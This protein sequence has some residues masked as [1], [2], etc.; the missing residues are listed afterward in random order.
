LFLE[1]YRMSKLHLILAFHNH[2]PVGNFDHVLEDCYRKSYLPLLQTL[3]D[4]PELK[5]VLHY[6]GHLLSW[7]QKRH[8]E[9][10]EILGGMVA[11]KR[12][13]LLSGGFYEPI[14]SVLPEKDRKLQI[15]ELSA[16][17]E[18]NLGYKPRGMWL[19]ER[20]WEPQMPKYLSSAGMEYLPVDDYHF[21]LTGL[22][23]KQLYGY[24]ITEDESQMISVFPGSEKLRYFIPFR[25]VDEIRSYFREVGG[26]GNNPLLTM[27]DD[28]EKFGSWPNTYKHCYEDGWLNSFFEMLSANADWIKTTTFSEYHDAF[29]PMGRVYLPTASYREMGEWTLPADAV[30]EYEHLLEELGRLVGERSKQL[31]R[32]SIWRAFMVKYDEANHLHKKMVVV[33]GKVH[34]AMKTKN[35]KAR[36]A[37]TELWKGQ[38]NDAYWHGI[39]GGLYLPH[40][41]SSLYRHL[42]NAEA[43]AHEVLKEDTTVERLDFDCDGFDDVL[44]RTGQMSMA[45]T[46]K[47]GSLTEL[48]LF[49]EDVNILDSLT[50]RREAYHAKIEQATDTASG[51]LKT[52]HDQ[53]TA[54]ESGLSDHLVYDAYR[55][56]SLLD[57]FLPEGTSI[58]LMSRSKHEELGDF[59]GKAYDMDASLKGRNATVTFSRE[60]S[61]K[62]NRI[63][64]DKTVETAG[65]REIHIAYTLDGI[66]SGLFAV[67]MNISL[68]G[69]PDALIR[70][71]GKTLTIRSACSHAGI[72]DF[73]LE[74]K[75]LDFRMDCS[76]S[77]EISLWHYPVETVSL[78]EQGVE[79][80]YQGTAFVFVSD[81]ELCGKKKIGFTLKFQEEIG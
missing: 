11:A 55:R 12:V 54:K 72:R 28:G 53:L 1:I 47:G 73:S 81:I 16:F 76:F 13:E 25:G 14:L 52:I 43:L 2:Q 58:E 41:R 77:E 80:L 24:Y 57:H 59:I 22:E 51:A 49:R 70:A 34:E 44:I 36:T 7:M 4:H 64:I 42:I 79:R 69:S 17:I 48:S 60:G 23:E 20:V 67:E 30:P 6:S 37:L 18:K 65:P 56:T 3:L 66:Y 50:R 27:A 38:C 74:E 40:L 33:S 61:V 39:F 75:Y 45:A 31:L 21:K 63:K 62:G 71:G 19:A 35:K 5:V 15:A 29:P 68:L 26:L 32:G 9:A 10:I 46:E 78:S 8:P